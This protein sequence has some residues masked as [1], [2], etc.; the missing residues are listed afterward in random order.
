MMAQGS[1]RTRTIG[2]GAGFAG[3]RIDPAVALAASGR[4]DAVVLEC[5]AE[6]TLVPGL[7]A[8]AADPATGA[9]PRLRRRLKPL[10]PAARAN[11]CHVI[12]N[13]GAANSVSAARQ[14]AALAKEVGCG[15]LKVAGLVG[16]DVL[17]LKDRIDWQTP[18]AGRLLGAHAYLGSE[19]IVEALGRGADVVV[20]GRTADSALFSAEVVPI[21][22]NHPDALAGATTVGHLLECSG[23]ITGG[24]F[25]AIGEGG[26][27]AA[28][29]ADLGYPLAAVNADG[30]AE[31]FL[32][33]GKPGVVDVLTCTLQLLYEVH[34]P[35]AYVTPDVIIDY[36]G[37]EF[38]QIG[39]NRVRVS[40]AKARGRPDRL[41]VSGFVDLP[42][43]IA[44]VEIG[45]A[46]VGAYRRGRLAA[47]ALRMRLRDIPDEDIRIDLVGVDSI[48]GA[49]SSPA[50]APP[51]EVRVHVS[52]RCADAEMAQIVEDEVYAL[53]LSGPAGAGSVRSERRPRLDVVDGFID[54]AL[55]ATEL[56]WERAA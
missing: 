45:Y 17:A 28:D 33:D 55:V 14:I 51:A 27:S 18:I 44:D 22:A 6:R 34:D 7:R 12:S 53:T 50:S 43:F 31:I 56:V 39:P 29:Y 42:G 47:E 36:T 13:L 35:S 24:N 38:E 54:R 16:D 49:A 3:D 5:L 26:L 25:D 9:D 10:L 48:L 41:K 11:D 4:A 52:V 2:C 15:G 23:Q 30:S 40:G 8:R 32:L 20:T 21:L 37:I 1:S 19:G 46:G